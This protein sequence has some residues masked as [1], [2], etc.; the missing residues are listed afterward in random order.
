MQ[1]S[2]GPLYTTMCELGLEALD[3]GS[4]CCCEWYRYLMSSRSTDETCRFTSQT[5]PTSGQLK[6]SKR[7]WTITARAIHPAETILL[8]TSEN[9][10]HSYSLPLHRQRRNV[11]FC[12]RSWRSAAVDCSQRRTLI[13]IAWIMVPL[14]LCLFDRYTHSLFT[15]STFLEIRFLNMNVLVNTVLKSEQINKNINANFYVQNFILIDKCSYTLQF[16]PHAYSTVFSYS[17]DPGQRNKISLKWSLG[18]WK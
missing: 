3:C 9:C 18:T 15:K 13:D 16:C 6:W 17:K 1:V 12:Q 7:I 4:R 5:L 10:M 2:L 8:Q 14:G 11:A